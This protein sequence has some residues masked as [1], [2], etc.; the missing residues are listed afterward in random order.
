[1]FIPLRDDNPTRSFPIVTVLLI[2]VNIAV[3]VYEKL[4]G[5]LF[6]AQFA[7]V[8]Y[9]VTT[10]QNIAGLIQVSASG[11][12][13]FEHLYSLPS[14]VGPNQILLAPTP[15]PLWMTIFT[16]MFMHEN[17]LHIGGNM[18][19]L[20]IF[21]NNVED[22]F[23][24]ARYLVFYFVCGLVA[25]AA[26]IATAP[27]SLIPNLGASGAIAGVLGSY[28]LLYPRAKVFTLIFVGILLFFRQIAAVWLLIYWIGLQILEGVLGLG[29]M[30]DGG[31]AYFAHI[32]GF[33]TGLALTLLFGGPAL[34]QRQRFQAEQHP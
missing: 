16:S 29:G 13:V 10:G 30:A 5:P 27:H 1:M 25:A 28:I 23:G 18:L 15:I 9:K 2:A 8:P 32:G 33:F 20:W 31:V 22:A 7:M 26:Q 17:L 3:F 34:G 4:S 14:T 21:G 24:K 11:R 6:D 19:F 12:L